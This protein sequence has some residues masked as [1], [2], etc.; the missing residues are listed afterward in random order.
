[1]TVLVEPI[2]IAYHVFLPSLG[3]LVI[4]VEVFALLFSVIS[5]TPIFVVILG[6]ALL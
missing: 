4:I 1:M 2:A 5:V 6:F 3:Y